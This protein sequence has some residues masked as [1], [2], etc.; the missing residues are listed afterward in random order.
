[1][2]T[3]SSDSITMYAVTLS[4]GRNIE[5]RNGKVLLSGV[6]SELYG[7][8]PDVRTLSEG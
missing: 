8:E 2:A 1:M 4:R 6:N 7:T 3:R 5:K